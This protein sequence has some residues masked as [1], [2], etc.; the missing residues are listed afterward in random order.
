MVNRP[1]RDKRDNGRS[2]FKYR[3]PDPEDIKRRSEAKGNRQYDSIFING[4]DVWRANEGDN[5][6]RICPPTWPDY[7]HY[8][9]EVHVHQYVGAGGGSYLCLK[10][11]IDPKTGRRMNKPCAGCDAAARAKAEGDDEEAKN[12]EAR[13][14]FVCYIVDRADKEPREQLY[15]M[16]WTMDRDLATLSHNK[17]T[18]KTLFI[19]DPD[20]GFDIE[21]NRK[22]T[23]KT[24]KYVMQIDREPSPLLDDQR[25]QDELLERLEKKPVPDCLNFVDNEYLRSVLEGTNDRTEEE[26]DSASERDDDDDEPRGR[27]RSRDR[28]DERSSDRDDDVRRRPARG[29]RRDD[30]NETDEEGRD[31]GEAEADAEAEDRSDRR[32]RSRRDEHDDEPRGRSRSRSRDPEPEED[33]GEGDSEA[34]NDA[35]RGRG[36][37]DD[38]DDE[39][40]GRSRDRDSDRQEPRERRTSR[41]E[42]PAEAPKRSGGVERRRL[43]DSARDRDDRRGRDR[44]EERESPARRRGGR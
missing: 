27:S 23:D 16:S 9:Y 18:G 3:R 7:E 41:R 13:T 42:E 43:S 26:N 20:E 29:P 17:R 21:I 33:G 31:E 8:G 6:I 25:E 2:G 4:V 37:R 40:R 24:T 34:D 36:R 44:D 19:A 1:G 14:R 30:E 38:R 22:G 10:K 11:N 32:G 12:L 15:D 5:S 35:P 28:D 39:P